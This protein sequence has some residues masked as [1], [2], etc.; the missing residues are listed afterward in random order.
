[1]SPHS[2]QKLSNPRIWLKSKHLP[3]NPLVWNI[4]GYIPR[5]TSFHYILQV[6]CD[7][8][9]FRKFLNH[10]Y[11]NIYIH[12]FTY[13]LQKRKYNTYPHKG[14]YW[15]LNYIFLSTISCTH[16]LFILIYFYLRLWNAKNTNPHIQTVGNNTSLCLVISKLAFL[17]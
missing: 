12:I 14:K 4:L 13:I 7:K 17:P 16:T 11:V 1:M 9:K 5:T 10:I 15:R 2:L 8:F 6:L 3:G